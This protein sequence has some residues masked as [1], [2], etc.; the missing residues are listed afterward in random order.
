MLIT[1][2]SLLAPEQVERIHEASLEIL[3]NV[4][5]LVRS[6]KAR[7]CFKRHGCRVDS[8]GQV[9]KFPRTVVEMEAISG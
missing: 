2:A 3:E 1:L 4:G 5:L 9:V 6:E 8:E 7:A